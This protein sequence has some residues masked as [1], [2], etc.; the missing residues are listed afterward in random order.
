MTS[1]WVVV[2]A[3]P[4]AGMLDLEP[5]KARLVDDFVVCLNDGMRLIA[6]IERLRAAGPSAASREPDFWL[7]RTCG[8]VWRDN[9]DGSVSLGSAKQTSCVE[10]EMKPT[11][12]ACEPLWRGAHAMIPARPRARQ[13]T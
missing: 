10:C 12:E 6:E 2:G 5:I 8:C 1:W 13:P 9:Q 7:C 4:R 3:D 11:E